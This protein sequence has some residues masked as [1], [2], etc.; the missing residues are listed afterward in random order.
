MTAQQI[1][2]RPL[3]T[4]RETGDTAPPC[5]TYEDAAARPTCAPNASVTISV[6]PLVKANPYGVGPDDGCTCGSPRRPEASTGDRL[7]AFAPRSVTTTAAPS[8]V[9]PTWAGSEP[10]ASS[11]FES[12]ISSRPRSSRRKPTTDGSPV[13]ST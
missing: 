5:T 4:D 2:L 9:K 8:V 7:L 1:S 11:R 10:T 13:L 3:P 6:P 12:A